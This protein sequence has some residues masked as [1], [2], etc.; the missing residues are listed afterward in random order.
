MRLSE[1]TANVCLYFFDALL[2]GFSCFGC[3]SFNGNGGLPFTEMLSAVVPFDV[4]YGD[5]PVAVS[6]RDI[7]SF[8]CYV[9]LLVQRIK[10][11]KGSSQ[12]LGLDS[13]EAGVDTMRLSSFNLVHSWSLQWTKGRA[14]VVSAIVRTLKPRANSH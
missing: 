8:R 13:C 12:L 6:V 1:C 14:L 7:L 5:A 10:G 3:S 9:G 11:H 2:S 4:S